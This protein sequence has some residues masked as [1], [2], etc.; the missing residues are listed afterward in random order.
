MEKGSLRADANISL[1]EAGRPFGPRVEL[2]NLNSIRFLRRALAHEVARQRACLEAGEPLRQETRRW[3]EARGETRPLRG[4][5]EAEDYRYFPDPDL[6]PLLVDPPWLEEQRD[7]LPEPAHRRR[8]RFVDELGLREAEAHHLTRETTLADYFELVAEASGSPRAAASWVLNEL[9]G[10]LRR[11]G[12]EMVDCPLDP[13]RLAALL[14]LVESGELSHRA[15]R[16]VFARLFESG[17]Q[18]GEAVL[19][20]GLRERADEALLEKAVRE[21]VAAHPEQ[22]GLYRR[23]KRGLLDF[24]VGRALAATEGNA[25]PAAL[26]AMIAKL[27]GE[28]AGD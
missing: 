16:E 27:L 3:D 19:A 14:R 11:A 4:K 10:R 15:A 2:K 23:G 17:E 22:V 18:P 21:V 25:D 24:L 28:G 8:D 6:P 1:R 9:L 12:L 13:E 7:F 5:E 20:L 26:R